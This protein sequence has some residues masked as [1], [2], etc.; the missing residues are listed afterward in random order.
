[1][2]RLLF[3]V[4]LVNSLIVGQC[5]AGKSFRME[6]EVLE[7]PFN[8][9]IG[10][11]DSYGLK[12]RDFGDIEYYGRIIVGSNEQEFRIVFDTGS[13]ELWIMG[14]KCRVTKKEGKRCS[15][16]AL[17]KPHSSSTYQRR[18]GRFRIDYEIGFAAGYYV[19]DT[20]A[21]GTKRN[22]GLR[23]PNV[24]FGVADVIDKQ[25]QDDVIDGI[26]DKIWLGY[27]KAGEPASLINRA[28]EE[29]VLDAPIYTIY[30]KKVGGSNHKAGGSITF[31]QVDTLNCSP[32]VYY[33]PLSSTK[34]WE[35]KADQIM[36]G[37]KSI[38]LPEHL[39]GLPYISCKYKFVVSFLINGAKF[40][41]TAQEL[42]VR[43]PDGC[44]LEVDVTEWKNDRAWVLG[45]PF[46]RTYCNVHDLGQKRI[47][48]SRA[49]TKMK[50]NRVFDCDSLLCESPQ[51]V[52]RLL[53]SQ[54]SRG[55]A[56]SD[57][58]SIPF[59]IYKLDDIE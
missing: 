23:T 34:Y 10:A 35:F 5:N 44:V 52:Q 38:G 41:L 19:A 45:V 49:N 2:T 32:N 17:Y 7:H 59:P 16:H 15:G 39:P 48:F 50:R 33:V 55:N 22:N 24:V 21:L 1:M 9:T 28:V 27:P 57:D 29:K 12:L 36:I 42:M 20:V 58:D 18:T 14:P 51:R 53:V 4:S 13:T 43:Y 25:S 40:S 6:L 54:E 46:G 8:E 26:M 31:G 56:T 37:N 30:L 11:A 47:G 3:V